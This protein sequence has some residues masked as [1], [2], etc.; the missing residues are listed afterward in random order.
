MTA[1]RH[2]TETASRRPPEA[3][4]P[5]AVGDHDITVV[6]PSQVALDPS[7][8]GWDF[9]AF[10]LSPAR[11]RLAA[12]DRRWRTAWAVA[13]RHDTVLGILPIYLESG[14][15]AAAPFDPRLVAADLFSEL[16]SA[17]GWAHVGGCR[18]FA[19]GA[20]L[21]TDLGA[22]EAPRIRQSLVRAAFAYGTEQGLPTVALFVRDAEVADFRAA[23]GPHDQVAV[24]KHDA[25]VDLP[26]AGGLEGFLTSL[27]KK[28][29]YRIRAEAAALAQ[30]GLVAQR[31]EPADVMAEA[32]PLLMDTKLRHGLPDH[33]ML[34]TMRFRAWLKSGVDESVAFGIRGPKGDLH[35]VCLVARHG[36]RVEVYELGLVTDHPQ[37]HLAYVELLFHAPLR[38]A[39]EHG[40]ERLALGADSS[41]PKLR[42]GARLDPLW[43]VT[44]GTGKVNGWP[45][46]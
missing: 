34:A 46:D 28:V 31:L 25:I 45:P 7:A 15:P 44:A 8:D 1:Q 38:Y 37:R 2:P 35:G 21:R 14:T 33:L 39:L 42:R 11:L 24:T 29:R 41:E 40:C 5:G 10:A 4:R 9:A 36:P 16:G 17:A 30:A 6:P 3:A 23:L 22:D 26:P 13:R 27:P 32:V 18:E 20:V 19:S 43:A 12:Q